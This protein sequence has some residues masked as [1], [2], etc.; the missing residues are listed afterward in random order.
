MLRILVRHMLLVMLL[1]P[2]AGQAQD[3]P[4]TNGRNALPHCGPQ[5]DGQVFC[6]F[7]TLYECQ[8]ISP[9]AM[10][11]RTGWRW[12]ADILRA[13][14]EPS[15]AKIDERPYLLPPEPPV[16]EKLPPK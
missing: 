14:G 8:L 4:R 7:G 10:E 2:V 11:R 13:C 5:M 9:N 3:V 6:R 1:L 16:S 12:K 15:P